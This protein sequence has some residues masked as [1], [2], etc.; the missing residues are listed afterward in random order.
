MDFLSVQVFTFLIFDQ[1]VCLFVYVLI[2]IK[3]MILVGFFF[4]FGALMP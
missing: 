2:V 3:T 4:F 1:Y